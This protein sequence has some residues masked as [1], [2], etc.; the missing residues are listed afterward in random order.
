M[1]LI[2]SLT[3]EWENWKKTMAKIIKE[4]NRFSDLNAMDVG[5]HLLGLRD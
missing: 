1:D 5:R 3:L 2:T 4:E